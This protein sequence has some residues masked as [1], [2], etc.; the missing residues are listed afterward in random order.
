MVREFRRFSSSRN[1]GVR[2][3]RL[4]AASW[5]VGCS[6]VVDSRLELDEPVAL[7]AVCVSSSRALT[8]CS[9]NW[10]SRMH[11]STSALQ[12]ASWCS[13]SGNTAERR[14]VA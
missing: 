5:M 12:S 11:C 3:A 2:V 9:G 1:S 6:F 13:R 7:V 14:Q 8:T 4:M 10:A